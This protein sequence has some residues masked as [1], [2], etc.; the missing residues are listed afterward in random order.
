MPQW[1]MSLENALYYS[2][3]HQNKTK[4]KKSRVNLI[5]DSGHLI[6]SRLSP[7]FV[8]MKFFLAGGSREKDTPKVFL[9]FRRPRSNQKL[10]CGVGQV[11]CFS[12]LEVDQG[13]R[14][15]MSSMSPHQPVHSYLLGDIVLCIWD[16]YAFSG[17]VY[18]IKK[19]NQLI[20]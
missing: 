5:Y 20:F 9:T 3:N 19:G 12:S 4:K 13:W 14:N 16:K 1:L 10:C 6:N 11:V 2:T 18:C 7:N 17:I 8:L 15:C